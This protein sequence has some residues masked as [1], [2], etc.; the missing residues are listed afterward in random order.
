MTDSMKGDAPMA[1]HDPKSGGR[2]RRFDLLMSGAALLLL[3]AAA[4]G[5]YPA[6][7]AGPATAGGVLLLVSL[8][9]IVLLFL[10][11][12]GAMGREREEGAA[13]AFIDVLDEPAAIAA[14]DG[15]ILAA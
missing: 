2:D 15:R 4:F 9:G 12:F 6:L 10:Y 3:L 5:A 7:K 13:D 1:A 11:S 14:A 8:A